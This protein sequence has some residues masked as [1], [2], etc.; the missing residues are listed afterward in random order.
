MK[1]EGSDHPARRLKLPP[2]G[3]RS[4]LIAYFLTVIILPV[5]VLGVMSPL[6]YSG[7][8]EAAAADHAT[9]MLGQLNLSIEFYI[10][11][12]ERLMGFLYGDPDIR[13]FFGAT[14]SRASE[15]RA[16]ALLR[17]LKAS[18][19]GELAGILL[20][21]SNDRALSDEFRRVARDPLAAEPWY[22]QA[23]AEPE[24]AHVYPKQVKRNLRNRHALSSDDVV[25]V[26]K[27][28]SPS[29]GAEIE[30]VIL[31]DL[32]HEA[33][34]RA[35]E[36]TG[37]GKKGFFFIADREGG[38]VYAPVNEIAY[39]IPPEW[40]AEGPQSMTRT[41]RGASY[42]LIK[43]ESAYT[44]WM[45]VG[46][47]SMDELLGDIDFL[48]LMSLSISAATL[49]IAIGLALFLSSSIARPVLK[50]RTLMKE[51]EGG[52]LD[53]ACRV[54]GSDEISQLGRSF[55]VMIE[56]IRNLIEQVYREQR[57]KREAELKALQEQIKPHFLYNTLDTI[58]WMAVERGA[59][60]VAELVEALTRLFRI[61]LSR[62]KEMIPLG[63][64]VEHARSYLFIQKTRYEDKF[65]Y[66][67]KF[68]AGLSGLQ[69]VKLILQPLV[70]NAIYHGIKQK[71]GRG[72]L[73]VTVGM[74]GADLV[75]R[76]S[77]DGVG[78]GPEK[79][80][81]LRA[82]LES[83]DASGQG[84]GLYSVHERIRL[85]YGPGYGVEIESEPGAGT[86]VTVRCPARREEA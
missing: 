6:I 28:V 49:A 10:E 72:S 40:L 81:E 48:R 23:A 74:D 25:S 20:A 43:R 57:K 71:K 3:L 75:M 17:G 45:T 73:Q 65:D 42:R 15:E 66:E 36:G 5:A 67:L 16:L 30:G 29:P 78:M 19:E 50:L 4:K 9:Q 22:S 86:T 37:L 59:H 14:S 26:V 31:M 27:A 82:L 2:V 54:D 32:R 44:G 61:G 63:D 52:K 80:A 34:E 47:F 24:R 83:P 35:F 39:R 58:R 70:E 77:D 53:V 12:V 68:D 38:I 21:S 51:V 1:P 79:L 46:V 33:I 7:A 69:V 56:E 76:V 60:D 41:L 84:F 62:G 18:H 55:N 64:E 8:I 13:A 85:S 11:E